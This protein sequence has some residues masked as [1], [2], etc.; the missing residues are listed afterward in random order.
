MSACER[1]DSGGGG[2]GDVVWRWV[3]RWVPLRPSR[4]DLDK[5]GDVAMLAR[6]PSSTRRRVWRVTPLGE[7][8]T[9]EYATQGDNTT[10]MC[11]HLFNA[12]AERTA[13]G[14]GVGQGEECCIALEPIADVVLPFCT[15]L[16]VVSMHP[17]FTGVQLRCGHRFSAVSLLWYWCTTAM[18][19]PICRA[20][21]AATIDGRLQGVRPSSVENFPCVSWRL[22]RG[23]VRAHW[24]EVMRDQEQQSMQ[25]I[26]ENVVDDSMQTVIGSVDAYFVALSVQRVDGSS[27]V[28][29]LPLL[30]TSSNEQVLEENILRY[31]VPRASI[32]RF[33]AAVS[34]FMTA[35]AAQDGGDTS[36]STSTSMQS[37][38]LLRIAFGD[39]GESIMVPVAHVV[40]INLPVLAPGAALQQAAPAAMA[41]DNGLEDSPT[42]LGMAFVNTSHVHVG[43]GTWGGVGEHQQGAH[44]THVARGVPLE[45]VAVSSTTRHTREPEHTAHAVSP[46]AEHPAAGALLSASM[47]SRSSAV[48]APC[49]D[50]T[51]ELTMDFYRFSGVGSDTLLSMTFSVDL[52]S[53]LRTTSHY[54][55]SSIQELEQTPLGSAL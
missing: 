8:N 17:Q 47:P 2:H 9:N 51:G 35:D 43:V 6:R 41:F 55:S 40:D 5:V 54:L 16:R 25:F 27:M 1:S 49:V 22:L 3:W 28:R 14:L 38:I 33:S 32:R 42:E 45:P 44:H 36:M 31:M 10:V 11:G 19:C 34:S 12:E 24:D 37:S 39:D 50:A 7:T 30:R 15:D 13:L 53:V 46:T 4:K 23:L 48:S 20:Q 52:L 21:Y 18:I 29:F 26:A